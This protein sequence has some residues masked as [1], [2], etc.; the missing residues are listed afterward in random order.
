[1]QILHIDE[2]GVTDDIHSL[3]VDYLTY[4]G[5]TYGEIIDY[6]GDGSFVSIYYR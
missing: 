3:G 1:M 2:L 4:P 5:K 6:Y